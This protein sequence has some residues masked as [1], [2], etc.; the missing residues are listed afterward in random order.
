MGLDM[1]AF[2]TSQNTT[3]AVNTFPFGPAAG[4]LFSR[5]N[6]VVQAQIVQ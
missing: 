4:P 6:Q 1:Y 2:T 3:T 5:L